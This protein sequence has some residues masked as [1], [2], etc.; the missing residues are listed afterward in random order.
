M[1]NGNND[2][3][4]VLKR[5]TNFQAPAILSAASSSTLKNKLFGQ[6]FCIAAESSATDIPPIHIFLNDS[7]IFLQVRRR[8]KV[9]KT[10]RR[11]MCR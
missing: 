11:S 3:D 9:G 5:P 6:I 4:V 1:D 2:R 10:Q 7:L 8:K